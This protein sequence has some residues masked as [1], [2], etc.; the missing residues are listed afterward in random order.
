MDQNRPLSLQG[1]LYF[2]RMNYDIAIMDEINR[3]AGYKVTPTPEGYE[4]D[5]VAYSGK[6]DDFDSKGKIIL[7][8]GAKWT[9]KPPKSLEQ[10]TYII[11]KIKAWEKETNGPVRS[12]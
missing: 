5:L 4:L 12:K 11:S 10:I 3:L 2:W 6:H 1:L 8:R 7:T 9:S